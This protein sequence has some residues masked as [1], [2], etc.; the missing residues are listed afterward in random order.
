MS[1]SIWKDWK[2]QTH[3]I[4]AKSEGKNVASEKHSE[5]M[6]SRHT[7]DFVPKCST[8]A[9]LYIQFGTQNSSTSVRTA[10][11]SEAVMLVSLWTSGF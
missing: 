8:V 11:S 1:I 4:V 3:H 9:N 2:V 7:P 10:A 5:E 6:K